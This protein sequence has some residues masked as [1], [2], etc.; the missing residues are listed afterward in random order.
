MYYLSPST[1]SELRSAGVPEEV[2][3]YIHDTYLS[4]APRRDGR[5]WVMEPSFEWRHRGRQANPQTENWADR[6]ERKGLDR[7]RVF[8][9]IPPNLR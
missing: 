3:Q 7:P 1:V 8:D 4:A 9:P 6:D 2:I 5:P